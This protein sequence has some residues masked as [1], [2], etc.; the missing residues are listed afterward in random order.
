VNGELSLLDA[1]AQAE[2]VRTG[3]VT[4]AELVMGP[5]SASRRSTRC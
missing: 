4:A 3:Q 2:L 1:T 5:S